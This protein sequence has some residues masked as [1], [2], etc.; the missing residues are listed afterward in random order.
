MEI[1]LHRGGRGGQKHNF[2][3]YVICERAHSDQLSNKSRKNKG[4]FF[5]DMKDIKTRTLKLSLEK[6]TKNIFE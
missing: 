5:I 1:P 2:L 6:E 4:K 3:R